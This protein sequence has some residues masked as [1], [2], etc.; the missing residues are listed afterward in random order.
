MTTNIVL[1]HFAVAIYNDQLHAKPH[2]HQYVQIN[3][4]K[5]KAHVTGNNQAYVAPCVIINANIN[6][7]VASEGA[8]ITLL[9]DQFSQ[10]GKALTHRL[11]YMSQ[12]EQ[13]IATFHSLDT[14]LLWRYFE[15][16]QDKG[17]FQ[18]AFSNLLTQLKCACPITFHEPDSR[19]TEVIK[20]LTQ[21]KFAHQPFSELAKK[22]HL[23]PSRL[24][25]LFSE[26][27]GLP[28]KSYL[29]YC[30]FR[31]VIKH[32]NEGKNLTDAAYASGFSDSAH[33]S[34]EC[35]S[36]FGINAKS[37]KAQLSLIE[38]T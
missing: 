9:L 1:S 12:F 7:G 20:L 37:L 14:S 22:V 31:N 33:L 34:R 11:Q 4:L 3:L 24:S 5:D 27:L 8:V 16:Q 15:S 36:L 26:Q 6:H 23:S 38:V 19:I 29:R 32:L 17:L 10:V 21:N 28:F 13:G 25:H 30:R 35:K 18:P 2:S